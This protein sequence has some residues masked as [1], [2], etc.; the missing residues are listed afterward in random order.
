MMFD[1][2]TWC[3]TTFIINFVIFPLLL[4][5]I[6]IFFNLK[7]FQTE[8]LTGNKRR[9]R[10]RVGRTLI[11][12]IMHSWQPDRQCKIIFSSA[13]R[14]IQLSRVNGKFEP[15]LHYTASI[16]ST[17]CISIVS[18]TRARTHLYNRYMRV[19]VCVCMYIVWHSCFLR[20]YTFV[21]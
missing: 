16:P 6:Y 15:N 14:I 21:I 18:H 13:M 8:D 5:L 2:K 4:L 1:G 11:I 10:D 3:R 7:L 20:L 9:D 12:R 17:F 19:C